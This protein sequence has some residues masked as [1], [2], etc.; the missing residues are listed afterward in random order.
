M[1]N[2]R[3]S[4]VGLIYMDALFF[5]LFSEFG[6]IYHSERLGILQ[7]KLL[8]TGHYCTFCISEEGILRRTPVHGS[9]T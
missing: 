5:S 6:N 8:W 4:L 9:S 2:H 7:L 1:S 3:V